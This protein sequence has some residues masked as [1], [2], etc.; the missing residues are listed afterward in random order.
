MNDD[1]KHVLFV[2]YGLGIGGIEKCLVNLLNIL[3]EK[4]YT[5]DILLMNPE[6]D[7]IPQI[8]RDIHYLDAFNYVMNTEDTINEI[9]KRGGYLYNLKLFIRYLLFRFR[10]KVRIPAWTV[11]K[12]LPDHYNIAIAYSQ[13]G[14]APYYVIDKV[15]ADRKVLWYH[16]GAYE[17]NEAEY[18][19]DRYYYNQ[20]DHIVAV[21][22]DCANILQD[23]FNFNDKKILIL[24][25]V[26]DVKSILENGKA[27]VPQTFNKSQFH[28]VTVGRLT[29]EKGA[30]LAIKACW[31]LYNEGRN[32]CWHWVGDGNQAEH[33]RNLIKELELEKQFIL[34]GKQLNPY[35]YIR[36]ADVY[37]QSSYYEAYS[38][39]ITEAKVLCKPI[40]TTDV[41]GMRDQLI[42]HVNGLIVP[43]DAEAIAE[44]IR[45]LMDDANL[46]I[47]MV[48]TLQEE[49][50]E[51][52][53]ALKN[54]EQTVFS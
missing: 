19:R 39:T 42:D 25:N 31:I 54:Y 30:N 47:R 21:S 53:D 22:S 41:G 40:V 36:Y 26:C 33:V 23:K 48:E 49:S 43:V 44:A 9:K 1:K 7:M 45:K 35:P 11:F 16:N 8:K 34:E 37:V 14:F 10:V 28:I 32:I 18:Q 6:Y 24:R 46:R 38:T 52:A 51:S 27:F 13:N 29:S 15:K 5:V 2:C 20:F 12:A 3:P 17:K 4:R 50:L